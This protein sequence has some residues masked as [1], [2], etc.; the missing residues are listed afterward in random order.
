MSNDYLLRFEKVFKRYPV[1]AGD[2]VPGETQR[3][4]KTILHDIDLRVRQGERVQLHSEAQWPVPRLLGKQLDD[5]DPG[6]LGGGPRTGPG[7]PAQGGSPHHGEPRDQWP[8]RA[9]R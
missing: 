6:Q 2:V 5:L 8:N 3:T 7:Q 9:V 4:E 1:R